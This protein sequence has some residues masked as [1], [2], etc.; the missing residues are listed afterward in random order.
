MIEPVPDPRPDTPLDAPLAGLTVFELG[1]S[2]A[3]PFAGLILSDLGAEVIKVENPATGDA[4][5]GWGPPF[6]AGDAAAFHTL[7]RG[8]KGL[9][10]DLADPEAVGALRRL[11]LA[12]GDV[13]IQNLRAG[14][15]DRYG[16]GAAALT[17]AKPNLIYCDLGAFGEIGPLAHKPGYDPLMQAFGGLMSV[18]AEAGDRPPVRVGASVVD[19]GAG[20]WSVVGILSALL[21]RTATG[22]GTRVATSLYETALAWVSIPMAG[23][24]ASGVLPRP[25]GSGIAEIVPYQCFLTR[26]GWLMIA[27]GTDHLFRRLCAVLDRPDLADDPRF[28]TNRDRVGHRDILV[29]DLEALLRDRPI[30]ELQERLDA[31]GIPNAPLQTIAQAARHPQTEA[32]GIIQSGPEGSLPVVGLPLRLDG[33]RPAMRWPTPKLGE[34][35]DILSD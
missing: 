20:L 22:R 25:F 10:V 31:A 26:G 19:L 3:A 29:P 18:T 32:L 14:A 11:I 33:T 34:H 21:A 30:A 28:R 17:A 15:A 35:N 24:Q 12:R 9:A 1:H 13:V 23:Y 4:A 27:A 5:R 7:N 16:L 6:W 8:K 2:V